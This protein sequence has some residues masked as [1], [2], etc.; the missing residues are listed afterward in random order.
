M[1]GRMEVGA[2]F[3]ASREKAG[4][5]LCFPQVTDKTGCLCASIASSLPMQALG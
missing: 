5:S 4:R 2:G 3:A 1:D